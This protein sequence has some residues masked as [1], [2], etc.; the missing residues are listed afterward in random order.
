MGW[1]SIAPKFQNLAPWDEV[2]GTGQED[3]K[4][5]EPSAASITLTYNPCPSFT[6]IGRGPETHG[7]EPVNRRE[8]SAQFTRV[9][10]LLSRSTPAPYLPLLGSAQL[11]VARG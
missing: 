7:S 10:P 11:P 4:Q 2:L 8:T 6:L 3:G 1:A 9:L 5:R